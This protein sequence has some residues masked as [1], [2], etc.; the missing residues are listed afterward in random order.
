MNREVTRVVLAVMGDGDVERATAFA[1]V[2]R[3]AGAEVIF[4]GVLA[5]VADVLATVDQEDPRA[6]VV[7][8]VGEEDIVEFGVPLF[9]FGEPSQPVARDGAVVLGTDWDEAAEAVLSARF[10]TAEAP[11][12]RAR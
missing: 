4:T 9:V 5:T 11:P 1:R 6:L 10:H 12:D 3:D 8:G 2:L 7:T